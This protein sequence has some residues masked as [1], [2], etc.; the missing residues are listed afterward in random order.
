ML[1]RLL[2]I[3]AASLVVGTVS[4]QDF[5]HR[6]SPLAGRTMLTLSLF[7]EVRAELKT[8]SDTNGK[9]DAL[10]EKLGPDIQEAFGA[11]NGDMKAM[12]AEIEKINNK[13]DDECGKLLSDDQNKRLRQLF[14]QFNGAIA[15]T[16]PGISKE[17][18]ITDDQKTQIK[19]L[20]D[21]QRQKMMDAFKSGSP[22]EGQ[23]A[24]KKINDEFAVGIDK[25]FTDDQRK[26]FKDMAGVKFEF[27]KVTSTN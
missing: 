7:E 1:R 17:L 20:Q 6:P 15:A 27:K 2:F 14:I 5:F 13:Y 11:A 8:S 25:L 10:L 16:N 23:A 22:E 21:D 26:K 19:K 9:I 24:M 3:V 4:A 12:Q 18:A